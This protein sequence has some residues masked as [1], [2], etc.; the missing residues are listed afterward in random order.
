MNP[1]EFIEFAETLAVARQPTAAS[2]RS[3]VSR[4]YY[5]SFLAVR[6]WLESDLQIRSLAG[7]SEHAYVQRLLLQSGVSEASELGRLLQNLQESRKEADYEMQDG[8]Q[9]DPIAA[10]TAVE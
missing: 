2:C 10:R 3:S 6:N 8:N 1:G 7:G 5:G 9:D 4:A